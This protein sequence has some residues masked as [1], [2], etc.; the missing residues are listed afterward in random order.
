M[1]VLDKK[2][3]HV[4]NTETGETIEIVKALTSLGGTDWELYFMTRNSC[5]MYMLNIETGELFKEYN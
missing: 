4:M 5:D 2:Q 3:N 1:W